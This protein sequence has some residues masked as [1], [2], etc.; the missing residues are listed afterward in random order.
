MP[1]LQQLE[2][3]LGLRTTAVISGILGAFFMHLWSKF[4]ARRIALSWTANFQKLS[5]QGAEPIFSKI[6]VLLDGKPCQNLYSCNIIVRN[7]SSQDIDDFDLLFSFQKTFLILHGQGS[8]SSSAKNLLVSRNFFDTAK[9]IHDLPEDQRPKHNSYSYV[10]QHREFHLAALNRGTSVNFTFL[11]NAE[12]PD[13]SP[14]VRVTTEK[15]GIKLVLRSA[16]PRVWDVS[17][18][19]AAVWGIFTSIILVFFVSRL[20]LSAGI[21][22]FICFGIGATST[23]FGIVAGRLARFLKS[24][25]S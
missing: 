24:I 11:I 23:A 7:E 10:T 18:I 17:L 1:N 15:K 25:F 21:I 5:P 20:G 3:F 22:A 6:Q 13:E 12:T 9:I 19:S 8:I 4:R 2:G 14:T 16:M